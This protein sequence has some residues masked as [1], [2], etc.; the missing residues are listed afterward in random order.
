[1]KFPLDNNSRRS[2]GAKTGVIHDAEGR[3]VMSVVR[4]NLPKDPHESIGAWRAREIE[5]TVQRASTVVR[6]LNACYAMVRSM[7][8]HSEQA[9]LPGMDSQEDAEEGGGGV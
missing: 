8:G 6:T 2:S 9:W 7:G 3:T 4:V 1:M 5:A